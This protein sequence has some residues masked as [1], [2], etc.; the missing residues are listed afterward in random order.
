MRD[1]A[2]AGGEGEVVVQ[3]RIAVDVDLGRQLAVA[4]R[5]H[6]EVDM[7]RAVTVPAKSSQQLLRLTVPA[8]RSNPRAAASGICSRPSVSVSIR[9]R[10]LYFGCDGS[11]NE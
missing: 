5:R 4:R 6:K 3:V 8:G 1:Q 10:R 11:K 9:R 2:I 7:R